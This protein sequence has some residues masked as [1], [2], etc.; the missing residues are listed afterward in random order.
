M[1]GAIDGTHIRLSRKPK[2]EYNP[3]DYHNRLGFYSILLQGVCDHKR[4]FLNV[5]VRAPGGS[6]DVAHLRGSTLW[7]KL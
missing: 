7:Q 1:W 6:H 5:C 2:Q 4:K 3:M